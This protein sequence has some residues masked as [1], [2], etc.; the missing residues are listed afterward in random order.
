MLILSAG[1]TLHGMRACAA[2]VTGT[3]IDVATD[4]GHNIP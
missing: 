3:P 4:H 1:S 2:Q